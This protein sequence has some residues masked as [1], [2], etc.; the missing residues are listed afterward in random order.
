MTDA[1]DLITVA[2]HRRALAIVRLLAQNGIRHVEVWPEDILSN[3]IGF[4][5]SG[6]SQPL[7]RLS[8]KAAPRGPYHV[9]VALG[10]LPAA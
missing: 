5:L 4:V 9:L 6:K 10:S 2:E 7:I 1:H 8:P 3:N